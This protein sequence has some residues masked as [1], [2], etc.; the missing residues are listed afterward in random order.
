MLENLETGKKELKAA[1][2][3]CPICGKEL[4]EKHKKKKV[5]NYDEKIGTLKQKQSELT[6]ELETLAADDKKLSEKYKDEHD[7]LV[8]ALG[9]EKDQLD[10]L[11]EA[12]KDYADKVKSR[13][14]LIE[15]SET[16]ESSQESLTE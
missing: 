1:G 7:E 14:E 2:D 8:K 9:K 12:L 5:A 15:I 10:K 16:A 4:D 13:D 6:I 11:K 3:I